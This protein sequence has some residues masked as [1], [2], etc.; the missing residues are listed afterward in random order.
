[1]TV[2]ILSVKPN[3]CC[4]PKEFVTRRQPTSRPNTQKGPDH[5]FSYRYVCDTCGQNWY[6][7]YLPASHV[8]G[9]MG[10]AT[11]KRIGKPSRRYL[12]HLRRT[13]L[14]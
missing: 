13:L 4:K 5:E 8:G 14:Q 10:M 6:V 3:G 7:E 2:K 12:R 1:M 11:A 9:T